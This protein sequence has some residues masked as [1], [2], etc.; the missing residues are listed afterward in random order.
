MKIHF[1]GISGI[2]ISA[3]AKYYLYE[4]HKISGSDLNYP[5]V[6][7]KEELSKID[8]YLGHNAENLKE[9]VDLVIY[10]NAISKDNSELLKAKKLKI[11]TYSYPKAL[12]ELTKKYFTIAV[13]GMHGKSTTTAMIANLLIKAGFDPLVIIGSKVNGFGAKGEPSNFRY[14]QGEIL[15]I[16]ADEYKA[17][18]LYHYPDIIVITNIE[19]EHLDYYKNLKNILKTFEKFIH[20]LNK[21]KKYRRNFSNLGKFLIVNKDDELAFNLAQKIKDKNIKKIFYSLK[22]KPKGL[23]L[24]I[25]GI[26]NISN[27]LSVYKIGK[28]FNLDKR[29]ILKAL[30]EFKGIWRRLEFKGYLKGAKI[31]DD[32]GHHPTEIKATLQAGREILKGNG[33]LYLVF[34]PHQYYRTLL[35]FDQFTKCFELADVLILTDIYSVAGREKESIKKKVNAEILWRAIEKPKNKFYIKDFE[36]IKNFLK[37]NLKKGDICIIMGAGD[38]WKLTEELFTYKK[39]GK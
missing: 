37:K 20:R 35:L 8:F 30:F 10:T 29:K 15:V 21:E 1:I 38:I 17:G 5:N 16:E 18:F 28:I 26:H 24:S 12:G 34:Q 13:S 33:K 39:K 25:P 7:T 31:F 23:K 6:F 36:G 27:S 11:K 14:G 4:G 9:D 32:Y 2:G 3:L 19:E 22:E